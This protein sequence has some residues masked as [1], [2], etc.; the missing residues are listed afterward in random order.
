MK[1]SHKDLLSPDSPNLK[2]KRSTKVA[3]EDVASIRVT[4]KSSL[5]CPPKKKQVDFEESKEV[6]ETSEFEMSTKDTHEK[7]IKNGIVKSK[8][9]RI[10]SQAQPETK[11]TPLRRRRASAKS[12]NFMNVLNKMYQNKNFSKLFDVS[13][14]LSKRTDQPIREKSSGMNLP[15]IIKVNI[16]SQ[17]SFPDENSSKD[18]SPVKQTQYP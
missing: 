15:N 9:G 13:R 8:R 2:Q 18:L 5:L 6:K 4:R 17:E 7:I 11:A 10:S 3:K 12:K 16:A 1:N 14:D